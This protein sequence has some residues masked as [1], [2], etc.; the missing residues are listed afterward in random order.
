VINLID[1][2][3]VGDKL[4]SPWRKH[5]KKIDTI[6][7]FDPMTENY[8]VKEIDFKVIHRNCAV[9]SEEGKHP[10]YI[11][12]K[13]ACSSLY[14]MNQAFLTETFG[15]VLEKYQLK[16]TIQVD[17]VRLDTLIGQQDID[18]DFIKVDAQGADIEVVRSLGKYLQEQIVGIHI[19]LLF[20]PLYIGASLFAEADAFLK[21]HNFELVKSLRKRNTKV[22]ND[23]LYIRQDKTKKKQIKFIRKIYKNK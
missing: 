21:K 5:K 15:E 8:Q 9:F 11:Y 18:F 10:F 20:K 2:G 23:F 6:L 22:F 13:E 14:K 19:E 12:N 17:C 16:K 1:V 4:F 7:A 3:C